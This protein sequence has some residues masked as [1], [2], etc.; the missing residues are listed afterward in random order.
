M[1]SMFKCFAII[2]I[3]HSL[4]LHIP[5]TL[6]EN[7]PVYN[8]ISLQENDLF[9]TRY[10]D[11][12]GDYFLLETTTGIYIFVKVPSL[13]VV[14]IQVYLL[15]V[16]ACKDYACMLRSKSRLIVVSLFESR[17]SP[18]SFKPNLSVLFLPCYFLY[19]NI[20]ALL[21]IYL[22][23]QESRSALYVLKWGVKE[24]FDE[25]KTKYQD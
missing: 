1:S 9:Q 14:Y 2:N 21:W 20:F 7:H 15:Y 5:S 10:D 16:R 18:D 13:L 17:L 8:H 11:D 25:Y 6:I 24:I 12:N 4:L 3:I 19:M 23:Q 22:L